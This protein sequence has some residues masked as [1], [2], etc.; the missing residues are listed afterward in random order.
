MQ[1]GFSVKQL[2]WHL[3]LFLTV[4]SPMCGTVA[5]QDSFVW[6]SGTGFYFL[7]VSFHFN[8]LSADDSS[9]SAAPMHVYRELCLITLTHMLYLLRI[10]FFSSTL[11]CIIQLA[12][13]FR[14]TCVKVYISAD[15][16]TLTCLFFSL[17]FF[18]FCRL[19]Y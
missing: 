13:L 9:F 11:V 16:M 8:A 7:M 12:A 6:D 10:C 19:G 3:F 17:S 5:S 18:L 4:P 15:V 14:L 2:M 1:Y